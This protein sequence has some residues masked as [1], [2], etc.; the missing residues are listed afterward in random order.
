MYCITNYISPNIVLY[1]VEVAVT[2]APFHPTHLIF[3]HIN[4]FVP[5]DIFLHFSTDWKQL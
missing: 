3:C 4:T 2:H 1:I 5:D